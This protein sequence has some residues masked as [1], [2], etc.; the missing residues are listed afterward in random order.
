MAFRLDIKLI[1]YLEGIL[2][3]NG[4]CS[5]LQGKLSVDFYLVRF[6]FD[7]TS[8]PREDQKN[9]KVDLLKNTEFFLI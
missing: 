7:W 2:I 6:G 9:C 5:L 8:N 1:R 4:L 3:I